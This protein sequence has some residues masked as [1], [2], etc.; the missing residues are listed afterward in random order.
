MK[1]VL[2]M[3][4]LLIWLVACDK[5]S[6][7]GN[8]PEVKPPNPDKE[9]HLKPEVG[10]DGKIIVRYTPKEYVLQVE[11]GEHT[12][13][14]RIPEGYYS[15]ASSKS[16]S[17]LRSNIKSIVT[18]GHTSLS[19]TSSTSSDVWDMCEGGDENPY[20]KNWHKESNRNSNKSYT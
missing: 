20:N 3:L 13:S 12:L 5:A 16:G 10:S 17:Q 18:S 1:Q 15:S 11:E 19:Y 14:V 8:G 7:P 2:W 9:N 4:S 6:D